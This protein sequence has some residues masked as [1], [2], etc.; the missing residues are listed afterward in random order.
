MNTLTVNL[1][2]E[3]TKKILAL[4]CV[5]QVPEPVPVPEP[6][7]VPIPEPTPTPIPTPT[8]VPTPQPVEPPPI[9]RQVVVTE[10]AS[11]AIANAVAG[12]ELLIHPGAWNVAVEYQLTKGNITL[13]GVPDASGN[14]PVINRFRFRSVH[15]VRLRGLA[16]S[17]TIYSWDNSP[18]NILIENCEARSIQFFR[19]TAP[20]RIKNITLR[21]CSVIDAAKYGF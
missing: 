8:P 18:A 3:D 7:P 14:K 12:D 6:S 19:G 15:N 2:D 11:D 1:S 9:L 21:D 17:N 5:S 20:A 10:N 16:C 13:T 4:L